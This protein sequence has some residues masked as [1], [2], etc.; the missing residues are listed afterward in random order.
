MLVYSCLMRQLSTPTKI[1]LA[2][3]SLYTMVGQKIV[4]IHFLSLSLLGRGQIKKKRSKI[5]LRHWSVRKFPWYILTENANKTLY[6]HIQ[7]V[8]NTAS[9]ED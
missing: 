7:D 1:I 6:L 9:P 3:K 8:L 2:I 4:H 5:V